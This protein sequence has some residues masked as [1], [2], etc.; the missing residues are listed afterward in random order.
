MWCMCVCVGVRECVRV[1]RLCVVGGAFIPFASVGAT[2]RGLGFRGGGGGV[3]GGRG[4]GGGGSVIY[5]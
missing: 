4:K 5:Y 1:Y 3:G 2:A